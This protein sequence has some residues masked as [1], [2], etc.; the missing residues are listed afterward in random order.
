ML[1][2]NLSICF[3][4]IEEVEDGRIQKHLYDQKFWRMTSR[5]MENG[6]EHFANQ[7]GQKIRYENEKLKKKS[8]QVGK[9]KSNKR[10]KEKEKI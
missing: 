10:K 3:T 4:P 7:I 9:D 8:K 5:I 2:Q 1:T 6:Y